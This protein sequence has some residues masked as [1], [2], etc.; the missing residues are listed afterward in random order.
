[1]ATLT[2]TELAG[3]DVV[4][5]GGTGN[6]GY[7]LVD[8]FVRAGARAIVPSRSPQKLERL[9]ARLGP[10]TSERVVGIDG[11]IGTPEGAAEVQAQI[12][13]AA[14]HLWAA[15]SAVTSWHQVPSMYQAGFADFKHVIETGLFAHYLAAQTLL[16]LLA[17]DGAYTT[18]NGPAGFMGPPP[19]GGGAMAVTA[20]AQAKLMQAF[21]VETGGRPRVNDVIMVAFLGPG[22]TRQGSPLAGEEVGDFVA[23]LSSPAGAAVH[24]QTITLRDPAQVQAAL[25]GSCPQQ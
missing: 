7:F 15:A 3:R 9:R 4:V 16:P 12:R 8:G 14:P 19:P 20:A 2:G 23:A 1:M 5:A 25:A 6:V 17:E 13:E 11:D 21:G 24:N 18:I 10:D 22:G